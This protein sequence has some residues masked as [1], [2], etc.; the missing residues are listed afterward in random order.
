MWTRRFLLFGLAIAVFAALIALALLALVLAGIRSAIAFGFDV[1]SLIPFGITGIVAYPLCWYA[2][3]FRRRSYARRD[4]F[5]LIALT[6]ATSCLL[7]IVML[8][9]WTF[10]QPSFWQ[11]AAGVDPADLKA[12]AWWALSFVTVPAAMAFFVLVAALFFAIPFAVTAAPVA[13]AHRALMLIWFD[14]GAGTA[15]A[16][17]TATTAPRNAG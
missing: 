12:G 3:I 4:T 11:T 13:F 9:V 10:S 2:V 15:A 16:G 17:Q 8:S 7:A 14:P 6:Y 1:S 5:R